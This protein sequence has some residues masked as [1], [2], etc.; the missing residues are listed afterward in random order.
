MIRT[1]FKKALI[2]FLACQLVFAYQTLAYN[3]S[4][5]QGHNCVN[6]LPGASG[7]GRY[8]YDTTGPN[9]YL[10]GEYTSKECCELLC[11]LCPVYANTGRLQKTFTDLTVP[12][13]GPSLTITRTYQSQDWSTSLLGHGWMFNFGKKLIITR[14]KE[15]EKVIGVR[16]ETGEKNFFKEDPN[17]TLELLA[18]YGVSY[19]ISKDPNGIYTILNRDGSI[20][21]LNADGKINRILDKNGNELSFQYNSVGCLSRITNVSGNYVDFQLGPN[22][23]IASISDNLG[24]TVSYTYDES[25]N[26]I[27]STDPMGFATQYVYDT[28]N[29]LTEIIDP[30]G[31]IVLAVT[32]D[33]F[34]PPRIATFTEKGET[35]TINYQIDHTIKTDSSGN[36]WTYYFNDV[37]IIEKVV[38]P[39]GNVTQ[40]HH[41]K[42]TSTSL[43]WQEDAGGNRTTYTYDEYGNITSKT[44]PIGNT[45]TY[46]YIAATNRME[47]E[48]DP[49]GV[50]TKYQYDA[51]GNR[52]AV[53]RDFGGPLQ[54]TTAYTYN[55]KGNQTSVTDP[56]GNTTT[57]E[58]DASGNLIKITNPLGN[59]TTYTYDSRGN[60][61]TE[62]NALGNTT[63][64]T[65]DLMN[66]V[67]SVT[68][69]LSNTTNYAYDASGNQ[70]SWTNANGNTTTYTYDAYNRLIQVTDAL[71]NTTTYTYDSRGNQTSM[72]D[73]NGNTTTYTY[74][75]LN[76]LTR[77]TDALGGQ[78]NYTYDAA[79][80]V[81]TITDSCGNVTTFAYDAMNRKVSQTSTAGETTSYTYDAV[82][83][84]VTE[85]DAIGNTTTFTYDRLNRLVTKT[86]QDSSTS[87]YTYD[88]LGRMLTG[89]NADSTLTYSY[90]T[91]GRVTQSTLNGQT[92]SYAYDGVGNRIS[93]T[94]PEG[95]TIQYT[96]NAAKQVSQMQ[97]S[98]G[99]GISY[100]YDSLNRIVRKD[101]SGGSY[102][103]CAFDNAGR[104]TQIR[105]L[106][107]N[108][109]SLYSQ[110]NTFDS[111]GNIIS[112]TTD[113]GITNYTY[114][115]LYQLTSATH[116]TQ[117]QETF[118][119]D[120]IGNRLTSADYS[121]WSYNNRNQLTGYNGVTF[122]YDEN[123]NTISKTDASGITAYTYDFENRITRIDFPGGGYATYKYDVKGRRIEK[124][125]NGNVKKYVYDKNL[126]L[127]EYDS[128]GNLVRNY[129]YGYADINP[130]ILYQ[131]DNI[132]YFYHD[133][134]STTQKITD[135]NGNIVWEALYDSFGKANITFESVSNNLRFPGQYFDFESLLHYNCFR[136]YNPMIGRYLTFD[137]IFSVSAPPHSYIYVQNNPIAR[138]DPSG[139]WTACSGFSGDLKWHAGGSGEFYYCTDDQRHSLIRLCLGVG[140]GYGAMINIF[141]FDPV[142]S[143]DVKGFA[144]TGELSASLGGVIGSLG[145][146]GSGGIQFDFAKFVWLSFK[147]HDIVGA[148]GASLSGGPSA[149]VIAGVGA[150]VGGDASGCIMYGW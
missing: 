22:G 133:H 85:T 60:K 113:I 17:G 123:G 71:G 39:L 16:Q 93:I 91:I 82:G 107:G 50:V 112:K 47:T 5:D 141:E 114:D 24:R 75:I 146:E 31:N 55:S 65:Y 147:C 90:D 27:A 53:I 115:K 8:A 2:V 80:N 28:Q 13:V 42:V 73:G 86:Y 70:I 74:D 109:S 34:Q 44:D 105:H 116:P 117:S 23:K 63:T 111:V 131:N 56:L 138:M 59:V 137:P 140:V 33:S 142:N 103:T 129:F 126:L 79:G 92:I 18:Y 48:T 64:Y 19:E 35:W 127:A 124:D 110:S 21:E 30:R 14:N 139:L 99:K 10:G 57:Y 58:Y 41:N 3:K 83:N 130:S 77:Q 78:T 45:W 97:L 135:E 119:Y 32:Y 132:Y 25:G 51:N 29:Q 61:L 108:G 100:S 102:S 136:Y 96:Y 1:Y 87:S 89:T 149:K 84:K 49:C 54:N 122:A 134:L 144:L 120:A 101:Y 36:S 128:S 76:H 7:W 66:R 148:A 12:G 143:I 81:L 88:V 37:G 46:T 106:K 95:E 118:T 38:D 62:T 20:Q 52:T 150:A 104:L 69:A 145:G 72:T 98:N 4:W 67:L 15:G 125:V 6:T 121:N 94:T 43:D 9:D 68:D 11:K 40:Q 26:L